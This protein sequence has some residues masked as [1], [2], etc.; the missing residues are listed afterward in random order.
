MISPLS[1]PII[2]QKR[3]TYSS[4][5]LPKLDPSEKLHGCNAL[6]T[7]GSRGIGLA[8][9]TR[10]TR[11]GINCT[12]LGRDETTL[13]KAAASLDQIDCRGV[14]ARRPQV[15]TGDVSS[16]SFW[17]NLASGEV[18]K[19]CDILV[20]AAGIT[21]LSLLMRE[22]PETLEQVVQ[23]NLMGTMWACKYA[24]RAMMRSKTS[25]VGSKSII[26]I[27][28]LLAMQGGRGSAAYA[29]SKAG[30]VGLT[31]SLAAEMGQGGVRVNCILPGYIETDMTR[32]EY[33]IFYSCERTGSEY[34]Y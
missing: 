11:A 33:C 7:G 4:D 15:V 14:P 17:K 25:K 10:F 13:E 12:L 1:V 19:P 8:I 2:T 16:L 9:A 21:H 31:R 26:N 34:L 5:T 6:I 30:I 28:S 18:A 20:N 24:G 27:S 3:Q 23:T 22:E 29:A 32:C